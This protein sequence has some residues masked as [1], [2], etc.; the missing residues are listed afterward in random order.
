[1]KPAN[2]PGRVKARREGALRRM[3][4]AKVPGPESADS[5]DKYDKWLE[6]RKQE[7]K[8]LEARIN[9]APV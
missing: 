1:M 5:Q 4:D 8:T 2:F 3:K 7:M 6:R 9:A